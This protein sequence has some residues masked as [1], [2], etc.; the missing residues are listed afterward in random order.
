M[1]M[2]P[3]HMTLLASGVCF[4]ILIGVAVAEDKPKDAATDA[5][6]KPSE[7]LTVPTPTTDPV[8]LKKG[9]AAF[10][11][12]ALV[13]Q[14]PRCQN[15]HPVGDRPLQKDTGVPHAMNISRKSVKAGLKC[16]TC[17]REKNADELNGGVAGGPPGAPHWG[18]P[19][20]DTPMVFQNKT[21]HDLCQQLRDPKTNGKK[22]LAQLLAHVNKDP[23]VL[24]GWNPGKGRTKPPL[25]HKVFVQNFKQWTDAGG[26][27][28]DTKQT[29]KNASEYKAT[30]KA[31]QKP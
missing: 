18:L 2:N 22:T 8:V 20:E 14:S 13:L 29:L 4:L 23:L 1:R 30:K 11:N 6:Q 10:L 27:C 12:V 16:S 5:T 3:K 25:T 24:W 19:P 28:P 17:H 21:P 26:P 15:C 7:T 9:Q 31:G